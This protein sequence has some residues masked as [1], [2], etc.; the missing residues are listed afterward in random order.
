LLTF[1]CFTLINAFNVYELKRNAMKKL[2]PILAGILVYLSAQA[3]HPNILIS[4]Q[5]S[6]EEP[7]ICVSY[8]NPQYMVA[9]ANMRQS[10][11]ST[12]GGET[13]TQGWLSSTYG[14]AGD[15]TIIA[16]NA[17]N[18][19]YL[20]LSS[21]DDG[22][23]LDRIVCQRSTNNGQT[24]NNGSFMGLS[25]T[26]DQDKQWATINFKNKHLF[27]TW[28]QF[29]KYGSSSDDYK[30]NIMFSKSTDLGASWSDAI[31][32]NELPGNCIDSDETTEG[33][34]P[35]V[36]PNGEIYVAWAYNSKIY[37]DRSLD[38]GETWLNRDIII[39]DQPGGWD[40]DIPGIYR[41][42]GL[43][44]T[45]F[46]TSQT[47]Y[48]G[49]LYVNWTDQRLGTT[50]TDVWMAK[51][52]DGG[53]TWTQPKRVNDDETNTHQF[54]TWMTID[55]SNGYLYFVF[56]DRRN[57]SGMQTDVYMA[58]SRNGGET[59]E[60]FK[61]SEKPFLPR[62]DVFF[63]D[64]NNISAHN[65]VVRPIWTR[66]HY[67]GYE[68]GLSIWTALIDTDVL[69]LDA[70]EVFVL[71]DETIYPNPAEHSSFYSFKLR[72]P[73]MVSLQLVNALGQTVQVVINNEYRS[74]GKYIEQVNLQV[75]NLPPGIYYYH[76]SCDKQQRVK[77]LLVL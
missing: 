73:S 31:T 5:N 68:T 72:E 22:N 45:C 1:D 2:I 43:P 14:V 37:F 15:P 51:S 42:N 17:G 28:T 50:D 23:W 30:S 62:D 64:Y 34:V 75:L 63:G 39:A 52:T 56:Y 9:G 36:G 13:W 18:F 8:A 27:V 7:S 49:N 53:E 47:Q 61:I 25:E 35:A 54:F 76:F 74:I 69:A 46:D 4:R 10:N 57:Y 21:P 48:R 16:D 60:N 32:I 67:D 19:Y 29:D 65:N 33:A 11:F 70:Q 12:D 71:K 40:Y 26:K 55:Q 41:C 66:L 44:V 58:L 77:K 3:Q 24:W 20:H 6:P 38:E 59:F